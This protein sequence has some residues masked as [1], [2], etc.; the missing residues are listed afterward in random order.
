[1]KINFVSEIL[2]KKLTTGLKSGCV[3][4]YPL[5]VTIKA[6]PLTPSFKK[7]K[8]ITKNSRPYVY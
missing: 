5:L 6:Y 7:K 2:P 4:T 1:M 8:L 3:S